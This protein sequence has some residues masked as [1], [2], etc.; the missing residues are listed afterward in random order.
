MTAHD[1]GCVVPGACAG[2]VPVFLA[3]LLAAPAAAAAPPETAAPVP[4]P[5]TAGPLLAA[6]PRPWDWAVL[7]I[8]YYQPETAFGGGAQFVVVRTA[9]SGVPGQERHDTVS[10]F[11]TATAHRQY[12]LGLT[13]A[14]YWNEDRD[15]ITFEG[16]AQKFPNVFWGLGNDTPDS[17]ADHYTPVLAGGQMIYGH[18]LFERVFVGGIA[19][20]AYYRMQSFAPGGAVEAYLSTRLPR[21][22]V[23][24]LGPTIARDSRD[25]STFPRSGSQTQVTLTAYEPAWLSDY[26]FIELD[27]D[28]R[29]FISLPLASVLALQAFGQWVTGEAP[30]DLLP[31]LGGP[32]RLRGYFQGRY[33]D[34][35]YLMGQAE[36]RV[37]LFWR[38]GAAVFG[39][40]GD[41]AGDLTDV[42]LR[43]PKAAGGAGL[44]LNVGRPNPL[45]IRVDAAIAPGAFN[46]YLAIGE[47]I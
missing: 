30:I 34:K 2:A 8:V 20:L 5:Q 46:F 31:A 12:G 41:V 40:V 6:P 15:R 7:P 22:W 35:V 1:R 24:G 17:A 36:W 42:D 45:N 33:R 14:K 3:I 38:L 25:D 39:A 13:A 27:A 10:L 18:R 26:R 16:T 28:Q 29:T 47:A 11:A 43:H 23:V 32:L 44:R 4:P 9:S 37:P 19:A 21:G